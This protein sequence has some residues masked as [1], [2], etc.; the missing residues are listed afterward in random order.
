VMLGTDVS[1]P[2]AAAYATYF[3][4]LG[5]DDEYFPYSDEEPGDTGRWRISALDLNDDQYAAVAGGNARTVLG[6]RDTPG[7]HTA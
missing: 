5:T 3:R 7:A 6:H 1:P 4:F 2:T